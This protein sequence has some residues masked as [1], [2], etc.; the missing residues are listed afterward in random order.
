MGLLDDIVNDALD[1]EVDVDFSGA[2]EGDYDDVPH[3]EYVW[4]VESAK[5]D[6]SSK[7]DPAVVITFVIAE[8]ECAGKKK[9]KFCMLVG[10]GSGITRQVLR[11]LGFAV[12]SDS[13]RLKLGELAGRRCLASVKQQKNDPQYQELYKFKAAGGGS[14]PSRL[15]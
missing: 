2:K 7:G 3:A 1:D 14:Q 11:A 12:D 10:G 6:S 5:K 8:G 13:F 4:V 9:S 15:G